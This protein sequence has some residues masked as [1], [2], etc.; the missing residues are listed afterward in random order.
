MPEEYSAHWGQTLEFLRIVVDLWPAFLSASGKIN[1]AQRRNRVIEAEAARVEEV[2]RTQEETA[3]LKAAA[4]LIQRVHRGLADAADAEQQ[5]QEDRAAAAAQEA[6][7]RAQEAQ[8]NAQF[9]KD[10]ADAILQIERDSQAEAQRR[11]KIE[12]NNRRA[13]ILV[14][15]LMID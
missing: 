10:F 8:A 1:P 9:T 13:A 15:L 3:A 6:I 11:S 5:A 7:L 12:E 2:R 14:S 4:S